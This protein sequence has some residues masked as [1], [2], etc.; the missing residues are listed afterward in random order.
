L[1]TEDCSSKSKSL[2]APVVPPNRLLYNSASIYKF[3]ERFLPAS[4]GFFGG[5]FMIT[6]SSSSSLF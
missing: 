1:L 5:I 3:K 2:V 6:S 4:A